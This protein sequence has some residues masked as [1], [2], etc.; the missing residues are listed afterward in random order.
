MDPHRV[1]FS[2]VGEVSRIVHPV[3]G[4]DDMRS[5]RSPRRCYARWSRA[6][7]RGRRAA[8]SC[9]GRPRRRR[10]RAHVPAA[11]L[12]AR[13]SRGWRCRAAAAPDAGA[14]P[15]RRG[16][17]DRS[18]AAGAPGSCRRCGPAPPGAGGGSCGDPREKPRGSSGSGRALARSGQLAVPPPPR[19]PRC[20]RLAPASLLDGPPAPRCSRA[21]LR[22]GRG[23]H[24]GGPR[25]RVLRSQPLHQRL[26]SG[27]R[28]EPLCRSPGFVA[29]DLASAV[30]RRSLASPPDEEE[31]G[32]DRWYQACAGEARLR[33]GV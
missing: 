15:P 9:P 28:A 11:P 3:D 31:W 8:V 2:N 23:S 10:E 21:P 5:S 19:L 32:Y 25:S 30:V 17:D 12:A 13:G 29:Q 1:L 33:A 6:I 16:A 20:R 14:R 27:V 26:S 4:G 24:G 18:R 7:D 22:S